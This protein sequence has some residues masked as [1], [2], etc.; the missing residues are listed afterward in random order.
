M[1]RIDEFSKDG[2]TVMV[3]YTAEDEIDSL[4]RSR[5]GRADE[6]Y[7]AGSS[8][9]AERLRIWFGVRPGAAPNSSVTGLPNV[10]Y[11]QD[12]PSG[13]WTLES[14]AAAVEDPQDR[15][16]LIRFLELLYANSLLP[17][18]GSWPPIYFGMQPGG[19]MFVYPFGRRHPPFKFSIR[20]GQLMISGCWT[21]FK[22]VVGHAGFAP[23][24]A[25]LDLDEK[26][27][28]SDVPVAGLDADEVWEVG[29]KVS[30]AVNG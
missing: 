29:E 18:K 15:A 30:Q 3:Q 22:D 28:A 19:W 23:L 17:R 26:G 9:N 4:T 7:G 14:F 6:V 8:G 25:M 27:P 24:A 2:V 21:K 11:K 20:Q 12:R 16:F 1:R 10:S 13:C 5:E